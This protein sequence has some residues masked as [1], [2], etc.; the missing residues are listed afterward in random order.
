MNKIVIISDSQSQNSRLQSVLEREKY[1]VCIAS[2]GTEGL[3][4][5]DKELPELVITEIVMPELSGFEIISLVK[6]Q[7]RNTKI[8]AMTSGGIINVDD[9]LKAVKS[10]GADMVLKKPFRD[11]YLVRIV[12]F[13]LNRNAIKNE[14]H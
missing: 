12:G 7:H 14:V 13:I 11:G 10:F 9:Y 1:K 6:R 5:I 8:I 4:I 2:S 3:R